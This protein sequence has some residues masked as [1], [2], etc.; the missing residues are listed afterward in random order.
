[1]SHH[2]YLGGL[3]EHT[4]AVATMAVELCQLHPRLDRDLLLAAALVHD[5][6]KSREFTYGS[7]IARSREGAL[8]GHVE[9]G[10]RL[11]AARAPGELSTPSAAW[12]SSTASSATTAPMRHLEA[13]S[14][15]PRRW[16]C[17]A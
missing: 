6:G 2:A 9:L 5:I 10:L 3:L 14:P 8:L 16:R 7:E 13:A 1:M 11:I 4:V 15:R 17:F 12:S